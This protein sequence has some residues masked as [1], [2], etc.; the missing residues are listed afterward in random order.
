MKT[1]ANHKLLIDADCPLCKLY[2]NGFEKVGMVESDTCYPYQFAEISV[3]NFIDME[4]AKNEIALI[5]TQNNEVVY[6]IDALRT[7]ITHSFKWTTWLLN[8]KMIDW[9][10]KKCY[11]FISS[12]RKI[13]VPNVSKI[14]LDD[15]IPVFNA[16]YRLFYVFFVIVCSS[17]V[18]YHFTKPINDFIGLKSSF[19]RE[20]VVCI[21][22]II[23]Q[24]LVLRKTLK[25]KLYDYLGNMMTVSLI[26]TVLLLPILYFT[27]SP[28]IRL[29]YFLTV[30][31]LMLFEHIRR[32]KILNI[33]IIPSVS[34]FVYRL[35]V[36]LFIYLLS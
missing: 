35:V 24:V 19:G 7:I 16:K 21:G 32:S 4:R 30:V 33:G 26:G 22:Q 23:W 36:L 17:I 10:L 9:F 6:G 2:G 15:C 11:R 12:N 29:I 27:T 3:S 13:I 28:L 5:N 34:W 14:G 18:L 31:N 20:L 1:L 8:L 25:D